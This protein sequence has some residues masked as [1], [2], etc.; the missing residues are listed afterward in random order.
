[1]LDALRANSDWIDV[2]TPSEILDSLPPVGNIYLSDCSYREM[3]EWALPSNRL[4]D[5]KKHWKRT[6][7]DPSLAGVREFLKGG[8]WRN[9]KYKYPETAE[10]YARMMQ[11][12]QQLER[13]TNEYPNALGDERVDEA[14]RDLYR[15]QCNCS[16][17]HGAFGGLYLP[18]L[19]NAVFQHLIEAENELLAFERGDRA[20]FAEVQVSDWNLDGRPEVR[21]NSDRLALFVKPH[22]G[23]HLYELDVRGAAVNLGA[24]LSRRPEDYHERVRRGGES[25][26]FG[27]IHDRAVFKQEGLSDLLQ[28]DDYERKTFVDHFLPADFDRA[29]V[30]RGVAEIGDF[31][32][33]DYAVEKTDAAP[34]EASVVLHRRGAVAGGVVDVSKTIAAAAGSGKLR[35]SYRMTNLRLNEPVCFAVEMNF[36]AMAA[37]ADDRYYYDAAKRRLGRLDSQQRLPADARELGLVDEWLGLDVH[38]RLSH[39]GEILA[40]PVQSVSQSEGGFEMVHQSAC[41]FA[42]W[43]IAAD[44][45]QW[46]GGIEITCRTR[47]DEPAAAARPAVAEVAATP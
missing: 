46:E 47:G 39:A 33:G 34:A 27:D 18:F 44:A 32:S 2:C 20:V 38:L 26:K 17:W 21:L 5:Y 4:I 16:Y 8:F 13:V 29:K 28:Y 43:T 41:V 25:G 3:T 23:G 11:V 36:A 15:G 45:R 7:N 1:F 19:R 30:H 14:R 6:E 37:G 31:V 22:G 12:S 42:V 9:F 40:F 10:M 24:S 35:V